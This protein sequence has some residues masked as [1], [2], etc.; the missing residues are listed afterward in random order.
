[1]KCEIGIDI[2]EIGRVEK[3]FKN[4]LSFEKL[5]FTDKEMNQVNNKSIKYITLAGKW[6]SKEAFSKALGTGIGKE[7][8]WKDIEI[9]NDI[10][11]KPEIAINPD[12]IKKFGI[13]DISL[14]IS[15]T[16]DY[17]TA[18]VIISFN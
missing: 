13:K 3:K 15:H 1:M 12:I 9:S 5:I 8:H 17:A 6:A 10:D 11:G 16:N 4:N 7:L 2:I 14:S 18:A